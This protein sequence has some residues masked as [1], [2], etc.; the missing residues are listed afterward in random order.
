MN[1]AGPLEG[2]V[3]IAVPDFEPAVGG[4]VRHGGLIARGLARRG[5]EIVVVTRRR[6]PRWPRRERLDGLLVE[7]VGPPRS[8]AVGDALAL[9][10]LARWLRRSRRR[11]AVVQTL[12][13][14]DAATAAAAAG[15]LDRTVV[16]WAIQGEIERVL[17]PGTS[18]RRRLL[19][20]LRRR[21]LARC[22]HVT[23]TRSMALELA[24]TAL[25]ARSAVI[26]VPVDTAAFRPPTAAERAAARGALEL[27]PEAFVV[28]YVGHLERR[29]GVE[30]L[31]E[32]F[33]RLVVEVA[34]ATLLLVGGGRGVPEDTE[35]ALRALVRKRGLERTVRFCGVQPDP[36]PYLRAADVFVLPSF[37]EGMPNTLLEAMASGLPSV[38]PGSAGGDELLEDGSGLVPPSND[39][40]D[41]HA[42]LRDLAT[43]PGRR[44]AIGRAAAERAREF[45]VERVLD[46]FAELYGS[47]VAGAPRG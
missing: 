31:V 21:H 30:R 10:G 27:P 23:L 9:L 39:P 8:G 24:A 36:R 45:D 25:P 44:A 37:R 43:D 17:A 33:A 13:W 14:P 7:R 5:Y 32:A 34:G 20:G 40:D 28:A 3:V 46:R 35:P 42:A 22:T 26:P 1:V 15:V 4:T 16:M 47:V 2:T 6:D 11:I 38:A 18:A 29:K 19:V 12:M 41:L